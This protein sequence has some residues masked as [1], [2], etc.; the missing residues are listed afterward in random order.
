MPDN[1]GN[2]SG[3]KDGATAVTRYV[4]HP[5]TCENGNQSVHLYDAGHVSYTSYKPD[6]LCPESVPKDSNPNH[7][8]TPTPLLQPILL[9]PSIL[10]SQSLLSSLSTPD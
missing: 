10:L 5:F 9:P 8:S 4:S 2:T 7:P 6:R 1:K 3:V